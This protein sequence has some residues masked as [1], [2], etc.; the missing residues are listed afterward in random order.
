MFQLAEAAVS[1]SMI[2]WPIATLMV[3]VGIF[4]AFKAVA[5]R[6]IK[7]GPN[8]IAVF[9]GRTYKY[10]D[11]TG[12]VQKRGFFILQ[13]GGKILIPIFEKVER[14]N[15]AAFQV[16]VSE[17]NIPNK[18]NVGVNIKGIATCRL[19]PAQE[20]LANAV[21]NFLDK[22]DQERSTFIQNILKGHVRSIVGNLTVDQLLRQ[23]QQL[24]EQVVNESAPECKRIGI[25]LI[26]LVIQDVR[27]E[28][29]FIE[30]LGKQ[31]IAQTMRDAQIAVAEAEKETAIKTSNA[32]KDAAQVAAANDALIADAQKQ[33]D[34]QIAQFKQQTESK[35]AIAEMAFDIARTE[36]ETN[37]K[38]LQAKRDE[39]EKEA[40]A[41]V[42]VME[43]SR[44]EKELQATVITDAEASRRAVVIKAEADK[45]VAMLGAET[46]RITAE[47]EKNALI[48]QGQGQA[49]QRK[50]TA[51]AE[52]EANQKILTAQ[53]EGD[54][55]QLI[56]K[57]EGEKAKLLAQAEGIRAS[58][59]AEAD[60][61]E[62]LLLAQATGKREMLLGEAL[63]TDKLAEALQKLSEQGKLI[64]ILDRLPSLF[65]KGGDALEKSLKAMFE[66][67]GE[68]VAKIGSV[69]ITDLGGGDTTGKGLAQMGG[70]VP[71]IVAGV[72]AQLKARGISA[73]ELFKALKL[74][75]SALAS[76]IGSVGTSS[77][78]EKTS[79]VAE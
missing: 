14:V 31:Q 34:I 38:V 46:L 58:K 7:V 21:G 71:Q 74:D 55:A 32:R 54:K 22:D 73:D 59:M 67:I 77:N 15:V 6:Y 1:F 45:S 47:G 40:Q 63:G 3:V 61:E 20:D 35:R 56:A 51:G 42:Q 12:A 76:M 26:S 43:A 9:S 79:P 36:Q 17:N 49:E 70:L 65:D 30:A 18:D 24:N 19:S 41:E 11:S 28:H 44:R 78:D 37:L 33:R 39:A 62:K 4:L 57:A 52:A 64:L 27:D 29:G 48:Q 53:A 25:Q 75:P 13:G 50:L 23:R 8:E 16:E 68:G 72:F 69:N 5:S 10:K 60:G 2:V 66:P